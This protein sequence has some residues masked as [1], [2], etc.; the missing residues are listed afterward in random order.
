MT[1]RPGAVTE[2]AGAGPSRR[3]GLG[4]IVA[5]RGAQILGMQVVVAALLFAGAGT[6]RWRAAWV[7]LGLV[8]SGL[9]VTS[10]FVVRKNPA[11]IVARARIRQG[12]EPFDKILVPFCSLFGLAVPLAAG[13]D[14]VRFG[15][16]RLPAWTAWPGA[17]LLLLSF[18]PL[19]WVLIENPYLEQTVRIQR[20]SGHRV[21]AT[22]PYAVVRHPMYAAL[23]LGYIAAPL[24]LG[25]GWA[26]AA[27][28]G[29]MALLLVRTA[30]ED[31]TLQR[32]LDGYREYASKTRWRIVPF[33]W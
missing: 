25:S 17:A 11:V 15:W 1:D 5:R 29:A 12:T 33:L 21:V 24:L 4:R 20:E 26:F 19:C 32:E 13:L 6:L 10:W 31:R 22:G 27:A 14:A 23:I 7:Y 16:A 30:L 28:A 2:A 18:I 8:F 3:Q 9:A